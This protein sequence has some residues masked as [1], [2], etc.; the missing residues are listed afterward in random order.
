MPGLRRQTILHGQAYMWDRP[1][2]K[3]QGEVQYDVGSGGR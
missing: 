1:I 2:S 3:E